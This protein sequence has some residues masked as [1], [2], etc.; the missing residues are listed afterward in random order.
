M[1]VPPNK[2]ADPD[3]GVA[4]KRPPVATPLEAVAPAKELAVAPKRSPV[5]APPNKP[6]EPEL[7]VA[8]NK[9]P[10]A[11][12]WMAVA[13]NPELGAALK[14]PPVAAPPNM[15]AGAALPPEKKATKEA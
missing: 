14:R 4:L 3:L 2:L 8:L 15:L 10:V 13:P 7:G 12:L 1:A 11:A 6:T 5:A 9:P